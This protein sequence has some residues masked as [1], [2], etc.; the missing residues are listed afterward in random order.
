M[1][2]KSIVPWVGRFLAE[3]SQSVRHNN[4]LYNFNALKGGLPQG[5][6]FGPLDFLAKINSAVHSENVINIGLLS[7]K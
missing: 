6:K 1:H 7:L 3:R 2:A 4:I 5:T